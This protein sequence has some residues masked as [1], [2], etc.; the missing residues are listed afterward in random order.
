MNSAKAQMI[1]K[2]F[3]CGIMGGKP[4]HVTFNSISFYTEK[5]TFEWHFG[6]FKED[7]SSNCDVRFLSSVSSHINN[8]EQRELFREEKA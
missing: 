6:S 1:Q 7:K 2:Y 8:R 3:S 5:P 4:S